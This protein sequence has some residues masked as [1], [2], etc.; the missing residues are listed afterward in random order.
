MRLFSVIAAC[1][2]VGAFRLGSMSED[3]LRRAA[4]DKFDMNSVRDFL[5]NRGNQHTMVDGVSEFI[6]SKYGN[7]DG[8]L[9]WDEVQPAAT[10][11]IEWIP[12]N[13]PKPSLDQ[14][15]EFLTVADKDGTGEY[16]QQEMKN[17][18]PAFVM[19]L[20]MQGHL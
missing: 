5:E 18:M 4:Q 17:L 20:K 12:E 6:D 15:K 7:G 13:I 3:E 14:V 16:D 2:T 19:L 10:A 9:T 11:V 8:K 1:A